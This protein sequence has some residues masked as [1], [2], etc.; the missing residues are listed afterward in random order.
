MNTS[1]GNQILIKQSAAPA[2]VRIDAPRFSALRTLLFRRFPDGEAGALA[3]FGW[4]E[5]PG[6]LVLTLA[7]IDAPRV[8]D[9][10]D[11]VAN[12]RFC[13]PYLLRA[14]AGADAHPL[15]VG[16]VHSH[17]RGCRTDAS[18][19]DDEMDSHLSRYFQA[20][21]PDRPYI[22]LIF[23]EDSAVNQTGVAQISATGRVW[24]RGEWQRVGRFAVEGA[25]VALSGYIVPNVL[26][27]RRRSCVA[28]LSSAFGETAANRLARATVA[29]LGCGGTGSPALEV[30]A[31]A[32]VDHLIA[33][34]P[35][36]FS[37]SNLER[38]HGSTDVDADAG[39]AKVEIAL[40]H[41]RQIRPDCRVTAIKGALPQAAVLDAVV[42][43]DAVV[44]ST[45]SQVAR[46]AL[47]DLATRYLV[48]ALDCGVAL[49]GKDGTVT[50]QVTRFI[51]LRPS[52]ACAVCQ[53]VADPR[54][55]AQELMDPDEREQ[56]Q[57]AA[58]DARRAGR[59][60]SPY[61]VDTP[62]LNTVGYLTT[63]TGAM[64]A[65]YVLGWL[66]QRFDVPFERLEMNWLAPRF[67]V[68]DVSFPPREGCSCRRVQGWA[69][70]AGADALVS[71]PSWWT[72]P[73]FAV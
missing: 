41:I 29:V 47:S 57:A 7:Q 24:M 39:R 38:V 62:Q 20:F 31:R 52:D 70:Q 16:V 35:D 44:G 51:R 40:R 48:P 64:A 19:I 8:G 12:I 6:G 43:A 50:G 3:R 59:D 32:G 1:E 26:T 13:E 33:V 61:W 53:R 42:H 4:R 69:D 67:Q 46:L 14:A 55:V 23:S 10:D 63:A 54:R 2:L 49:E 58:A 56:R 27:D 17:P 65:G 28:R 30:L 60:G 73:E 11:S 5:T 72:A 68:T 71:A 22:S 21:A 36:S 15:A 34:D 66:S 37:P 25:D 45:D 9:V 18:W